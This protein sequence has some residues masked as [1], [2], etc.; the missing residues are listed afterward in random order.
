MKVSLQSAVC[1]QFPYVS[2]YVCYCGH[3]SCYVCSCWQRPATCNDPPPELPR[4]DHAQRRV[5][6]GGVMKAI[7][8]W[9]CLAK[10]TEA[11]RL[12]V[13]DFRGVTL[14]DRRRIRPS[15]STRACIL[16]A[17]GGDSKSAWS[18]GSKYNYGPSNPNGSSSTQTSYRAPSYDR[19]QQQVLQD[20]TKEAFAEAFLQRD[21]RNRFIGT[22]LLYINAT[23]FQTIFGCTSPFDP[24]QRDSS[25]RFMI[26]SQGVCDFDR[27]IT[28][29]CRRNTR[30]S[31]E[32]WYPRLDDLASSGEERFVHIHLCIVFYDQIRTALTLFR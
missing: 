6:R 21:D 3:N 4:N 32:P 15:P 1:N 26:S 2:R 30:L 10:C 27:T 24:Q 13:R 8:L 9:M 7:F 12:S 18:A 31:F 17:R 11:S 23:W 22:W 14:V 20:D 5:R 19:E 28:V 25:C 16:S 29:Y